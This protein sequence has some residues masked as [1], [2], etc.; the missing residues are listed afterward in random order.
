MHGWWGV[1]G[2]GERVCSCVV[3]TAP[4]LLTC[5]KAKVKVI[6]SRKINPFPLN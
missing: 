4:D 2:V 1:G 5:E 3:A 6:V